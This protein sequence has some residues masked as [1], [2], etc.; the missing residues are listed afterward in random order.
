MK[1]KDKIF[2]FYELIR[3]DKP[4]GTLLLLW[5]TLSAFL[6][7][8]EGNPDLLLITLFV[9]G[10]LLMRS[11]GCIIND[12]FDMEFD[13]SV[14]RT[15]NRPLVTGLIKPSE[16]LVLFFLLIMASCCLLIWMNWLTIK[17]AALGLG[18][19]IFYPLTKRFF[20]IP[21]LFLGLAFSWGII[22]VSAAELNQINHIS[23]VLFISCFFWILAYD[24]AYA[25][26]DKEDDMKVGLRSS[27][28][29]FGN[30]VVH[31]FI[32]FHLIALSI[33][34]WLGYQLNLH[35]LFFLSSLS[36]A[37]LIIYQ[38]KLISN[39]DRHRCFLA[40]KNNNWVGFSLFI[41]SWL[42]TSL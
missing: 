25:M 37:F 11:A 24:T 3:A 41:G 34:S 6:V 8:T 7:L 16:A 40:F 5:P 10:T 15:K 31:F 9:L 17:V 30:R 4:I 14:D 29:T 33:W 21:Q 1:Y 28:L 12:Y 36:W 38:Y 35:P 39:Y 19:A 18:L 42:G 22:M 20:A 2:G 26:S 32:S 23:L 13:G 27:A